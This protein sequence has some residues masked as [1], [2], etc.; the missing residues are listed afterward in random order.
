MQTWR[1]FQPTNYVRPIKKLNLSIGDAQSGGAATSEAF[2]NLAYL[3]S[4]L[5]NMNEERFLAVSDALKDVKDKTLQS[6]LWWKYSGNQALIP[7]VFLT[8]D[9]RATSK[10]FE[11]LGLVITDQQ[12]AAVEAFNDSKTKLG[13]YLGWVLKPDYRSQGTCVSKDYRIHYRIH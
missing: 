5:A 7:L 6:K 1:V 3:A 13:N 4:A 2:A 8:S 11:D 12:A 9:I 10:E